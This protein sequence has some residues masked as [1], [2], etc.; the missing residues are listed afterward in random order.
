MALA[1][2]VAKGMRAANVSS[3]KGSFNQRARSKDI[4]LFG[5]EDLAEGRV[6][7]TKLA[8]NDAWLRNLE[9]FNSS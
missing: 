2:P 8:A 9:S 5:I 7:S 6:I 3:K 4:L 1:E